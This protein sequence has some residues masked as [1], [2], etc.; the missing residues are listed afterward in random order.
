MSGVYSTIPNYGGRQPTNTAYI[1]QFTT[2]IGKFVPYTIKKINSIIY[3]I[4]DYNTIF[5]NDITVLG[6]INSPSDIK[7]KNNIEKICDVDDSINK[8]L[9]LNPVTYTLKS[10]KENV[11][12]YG[13]IAQE[14]EQIFPE[15]VNNDK[16]LNYKTINYLEFV[17]LLIAKIQSMQKE[18]DELKKVK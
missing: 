8:L 5:S 11:K 7:I 18:I 9:N 12:H 14:T 3:L 6:S 2:T 1:K 4:F 10:D 15:L 17:P 16:S 13:L